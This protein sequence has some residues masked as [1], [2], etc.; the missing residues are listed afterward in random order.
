MLVWDNLI[1]TAVH[2]NN[3]HFIDAPSKDHTSML[4]LR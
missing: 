4:C 1:L 2:H 3:K